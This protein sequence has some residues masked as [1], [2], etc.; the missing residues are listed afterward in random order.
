[1]EQKVFGAYI[2]ARPDG[3]VFYAG[4]GTCK[5]A[6][7]MNRNGW[8]NSIVKKYGK[9][10][11]I[12]KFAPCDSEESAFELEEFIIEV[13]RAEGIEL[14]NMTNGGEGTSGLACT[15]TK[16]AKLSAAMK[17]R[18]LSLD[19]RAKISE[20]MRGT[21]SSI[22]IGNKIS[23]ALLAR[24]NTKEVFAKGFADWVDSAKKSLPQ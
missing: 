2:H 4:K 3:S 22:E 5:R 17:G 6:K 16:K 11:I 8:H 24:H 18:K 1:M 21:E 13:L 23:I 20:A 14:T 7:N 12:V 10:N 9:N 15:E 19:H